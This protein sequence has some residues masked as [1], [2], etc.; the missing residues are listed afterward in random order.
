M[1]AFEQ[2][3]KGNGRDREFEQGC[4]CHVQETGGSWVVSCGQRSRWAAGLVESHG[5]HVDIGFYSGME[6]VRGF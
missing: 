3:S 6:A 1:G 5:L 2:R 4:L